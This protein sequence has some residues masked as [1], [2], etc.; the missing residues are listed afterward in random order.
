M[1]RSENPRIA[2]IKAEQQALRITMEDQAAQWQAATVEWLRSEWD[3]TARRAVRDSPD[4]VQELAASDALAELKA[5]VE[6]LK[7]NA[8]DL[9]SE[10]FDRADEVWSHIK[11]VA[12]EGSSHPPYLDKRFYEFSG[13]RP[14]DAFD[15]PLR[16][17]RGHVYALLA[18]ADLLDARDRENLTRTG[19]T[20]RYAYALDWSAEMEQRIAEYSSSY[21]RFVS[22]VEE[23]NAMSLETAQREATDL[24]DQA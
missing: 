12:F 16:L 5:R 13:R 15:E 21:V 19:D 22:L 24:W 1:E 8:G 3:A 6:D 18:N 20:Y 23:L 17:L 11:G 9:V 2:E 10:S 7:T 14:P 4:R